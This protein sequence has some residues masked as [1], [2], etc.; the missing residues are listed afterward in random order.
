MKILRCNKFFYLHGGAD[1][2]FILLNRILEKEGHT[3]IPFA[4]KDRLNPP[5][6]LGPLFARNYILPGRNIFWHFRAGINSL[7][8]I[9]AYEKIDFLIKSQ[10]PDIA[11]VHNIYHHISPSI[12][13][14]LKQRNIPVVMTLHDYKLICP[15]YSLF[16]GEKLCEEC[17]RVK[18]YNCA[19]KRC[20]KSSFLF[21][22][23]FA[24][25]MAL[26]K[27]LKIY[28]NNV[29]IFLV[30]SKFLRS[31]VIEFGINPEKIEYFP[32]FTGV[33]HELISPDGN[34]A[35]HFLFAGRLEKIKGADVLIR[36]VEKSSLLRQRKLLIAGSGTQQEQLQRYCKAAK[37]N[38]I[39]FLGEV[40]HE[41]VCELIRS[42]IAVIVPSVW[43]DVSPRIIYESLAVGKIVIASD[44]GGI[45][46]LVE[47]GKNGFLFNP[48]DS[49][50]LKRQLEYCICHQADLASLRLKAYE[51]AGEYKEEVFLKNLMGL[52]RRLIL[53]NTR[54]KN[55]KMHY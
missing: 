28:E 6:P 50:Q 14:A 7:Y 22:A 5:H 27:F 49:E 33:K 42:S 31:K 47:D 18:Y 32:G 36:A 4:L 13:V 25:E 12:L 15:N 3:V 46:E 30:H 23:F 21:S 8:S 10:K 55:Q 9:E 52:Y 39:Q 24:L 40:S 20:F 48:G 41:K 38:N 1:Q 34:K 26:H 45:P 43:H 44:I 35:Q 16:D 54:S 17:R 53:N 51:K 19:L 2:H 29:D 37:L 11:H